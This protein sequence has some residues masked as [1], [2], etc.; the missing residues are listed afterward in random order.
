[1]SHNK[2]ESARIHFLLPLLFTCGDLP[3]K[4]CVFNHFYKDSVIIYG[5]IATRVREQP[6]CE[7][8]RV[9]IQLAAYSRSSLSIERVRRWKVFKVPFQ[10]SRGSS[11]R[12]RGQGLWKAHDADLFIDGNCKSSSSSSDGAADASSETCVLVPRRSERRCFPSAG[13]SCMPCNHTSLVAASAS[14]YHIWGMRTVRTSR[15]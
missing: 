14:E 9:V 12:M 4:K 13:F 15:I 3:Q 8:I 1:M 10:L 7:M 6:L 2:S 5:D 11:Q